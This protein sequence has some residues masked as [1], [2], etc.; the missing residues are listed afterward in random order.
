MR[1]PPASSSVSLLAA[2]RG[3]APVAEQEGIATALNT[4]YCHRDV[5][6]MVRGQ[7]RFRMPLGGI[8]LGVILRPDRVAPTLSLPLCRA[9][10]GV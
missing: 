6:L 10:T 5:I 8:H 2:Y 3:R 4:S 1:P 9:D 7:R